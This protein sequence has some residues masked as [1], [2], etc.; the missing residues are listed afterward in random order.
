MFSFA[1]I[2]CSIAHNRPGISQPVM[3]AMA[4]QRLYGLSNVTSA[5]TI[6]N[7]SR[8]NMK[9]FTNDHKECSFRLE[10]AG[11]RIDRNL[12]LINYLDK[13]ATSYLV[14]ITRNLI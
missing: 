4:E 11:V 3:T 5:L 8:T 7:C 10:S 12:L 13:S 14:T 6:A 1:L 9:M 2:V